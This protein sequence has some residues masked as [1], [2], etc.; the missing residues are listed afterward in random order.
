MCHEDT[1]DGKLAITRHLSSHMEEISLAAL[2]AGIGAN[3]DESESGDSNASESSHDKMECRVCR[4]FGS[5][6]EMKLCANH[7]GPGH[8]F[9]DGCG[10]TDTSVPSAFRRCGVCDDWAVDF[11]PDTALGEGYRDT[12][13]IES[14]HDVVDGTA[15]YL[16]DPGLNLRDVVD[17]TAGSLP[18]PGLNLRD[19]PSK[20]QLWKL[21]L[22][23]EE[24]YGNSRRL[25]FT[26]EDQS[27]IFIRK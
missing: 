7:P 10:E 9:H 26:F 4:K 21:Y 19:M 5:P 24:R 15:G 13:R 3:D 11:P 17:G 22:E 25:L 12:E 14:I 2:P 20:E 1:G 8:W 18:D 16:P 23:D 27:G 6:E